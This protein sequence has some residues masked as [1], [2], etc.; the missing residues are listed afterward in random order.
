MQDK[1]FEQTFKTLKKSEQNPPTLHLITLIFNLQKD[2][3]FFQQNKKH[4]PV[5]S[6]T[7]T[8]F[9]SLTFQGIF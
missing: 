4:L 6:T 2:S 5:L 8:L 9:C 7:T 3:F 1:N